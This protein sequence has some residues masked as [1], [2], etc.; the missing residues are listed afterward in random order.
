MSLSEGIR[1]VRQ[2]ALLN[3]ESFAA[4]LNVSLITVHRWESG[5]SLPN[6]TAMR[7][8]KEF[9]ARRDYPYSLLESDWLTERLAESR[10]RSGKK[11]GERGDAREK[12]TETVSEVKEML[13][14]AGAAHTG[15][16]EQE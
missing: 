14:K 1:T 9:C 12:L 15:K 7:A 3:Q 6:L 5:K 11:A 16:C 10:R 4:A 8:L 13:A 2:R